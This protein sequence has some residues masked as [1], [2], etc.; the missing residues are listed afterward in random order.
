MNI[1]KI[2]LLGAALLFTSSTAFAQ[3]TFYAASGV[4]NADTIILRAWPSK[5]SRKINNIPHNTINI[6]ATGKHI[7]KENKK[8]LQVKFQNDTGWTEA[9]NLAE[10]QAVPQTEVAANSLPHANQP[11]NTA[12]AFTYSNQAALP[13]AT[14]QAQAAPLQAIP[15]TQAP[16]QVSPKSYA[17]TSLQQV[18]DGIPWTA[19]EDTIYHDPT[20]QQLVSENLIE[21]VKATH[22]LVVINKNTPADSD[23]RGE[24]LAVNRYENIQ[25]SMTVQY[26]R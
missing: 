24:N 17:I 1:L 23:E 11:T 18:P 13:Q 12:S 15:Q 9:E 26:Q 3:P 25:A 14:P 19:E 4:S 16:Q 2:K 21:K 8:W 10:M 6:E 22:T 5:I 7:F 20:P